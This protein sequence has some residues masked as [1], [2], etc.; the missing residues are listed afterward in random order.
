[1]SIA[2][3]CSIADRIFLVVYFNYSLIISVL[4]LFNTI[5]VRKITSLEMEAPFLLRKILSICLRGKFGKHK[6]A[7]SD[8]ENGD[9][10][11]LWKAK[12]IWG[13]IAAALDR[14]IF[15]IM[16]IAYFW[17]SFQVS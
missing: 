17:M 4:L 2:P 15:L 9:K 10:L 11:K 6:T 13:Q 5:F 12:I 14:G 8:A 3:I 7:L 1:M 16:I